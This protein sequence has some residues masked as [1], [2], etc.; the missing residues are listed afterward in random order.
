MTF[1]STVRLDAGDAFPSIALTVPGG[2]GGTSLRF[3]D[4]LDGWTVLLVYRGHW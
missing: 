3:P 2:P 1:D 4:D